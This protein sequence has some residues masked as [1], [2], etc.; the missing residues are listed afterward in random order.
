MRFQQEKNLKEHFEER[1][2]NNLFTH[3]TLLPSNH[4]TT[5]P[6]PAAALHS[7]PAHHAP[8]EQHHLPPELF[9]LWT[10]RAP[11]PMQDDPLEVDPSP[12][13]VLSSCLEDRLFVQ[14][15][16]GTVLWRKRERKRER[17]KQEE[18]R[19]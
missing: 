13:N 7:Y 12:S 17:E 4:A 18:R 6:T 3:P 5:G 1:E 19:E 15:V 14:E 9:L 16:V 11:A 10:A 2:K 8:A